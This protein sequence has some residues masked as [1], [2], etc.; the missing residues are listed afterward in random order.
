MLN[1]TLHHHLDK[2]NTNIAQDMKENL[3]VDNLISGCDTEVDAVAYYEEA[4]STIS[5]G[6]FN[7]RSWASNSF[8]VI[9]VQDH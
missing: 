3:Y 1:A 6:K 8:M 9:I 7:L 2:H 4:R 5:Q